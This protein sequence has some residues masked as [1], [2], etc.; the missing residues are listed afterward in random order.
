MTEHWL[1]QWDDEN[2]DDKSRSFGW[3]QW[4]QEYNEDNDKC[5]TK[6]GSVTGETGGESFGK[7]QPGSTQPTLVGG[8]LFVLVFYYLT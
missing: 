2:R 7:K 5:L 4:W 6:K 8:L 1:L 3:R